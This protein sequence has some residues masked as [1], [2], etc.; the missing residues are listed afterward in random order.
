MH[1]YA[2]SVCL[3][4]R[5]GTAGITCPRGHLVAFFDVASGELRK[6]LP[7]RD[8]GGILLDRAGQHFLVSTGFGELH[9][10]DATALEPTPGSPV[11]FDH[12]RFDN[13]LTLI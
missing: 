2:A 11:R 3:D 12:L 13:H 5:R 8:A 10:I 6:T 1:A 7:I 9:R 4:V